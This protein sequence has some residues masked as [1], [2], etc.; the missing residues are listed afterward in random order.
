M[1]QE[2]DRVVIHGFYNNNFQKKKGKLIQVELLF[3][4]G[5]YDSHTSQKTNLLCQ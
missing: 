4:Y 1:C 2:A 5:G 3:I